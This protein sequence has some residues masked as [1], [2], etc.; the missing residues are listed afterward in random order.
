MENSR[1]FHLSERKK[2]SDKKLFVGIAFGGI[3]LSILSCW[4]FNAGPDTE[5]S[6]LLSCLF[7]IVPMA[8]FYMIIEGV[9]IYRETAGRKWKLVINEKGI[10]EIGHTDSK[11]DDWQVSWEEIREIFP[12]NPQENKQAIIIFPRTQSYSDYPY[13][14]RQGEVFYTSKYDKHDDKLY[15]ADTHKIYGYDNLGEIYN[16]LKELH[17]N[18]LIRQ[19]EEFAIQEQMRLE[20]LAKKEFIRQQQEKQYFQRIN[21]LEEIQKIDPIQFEKL[22]SSLFKKIGYDVL[23]TKASGDEGIDIILS[24]SGKKSIVQCKRYSGTVGQPVARDLYGSMIHNR[25]EEAYLITTGVFSL[26]AQTWATGKPIHLVDG[27]MLVE[28]IETILGKDGMG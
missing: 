8:G 17:Q 23:L 12:P 20:E 3:L 19:K 25:A 13:I 18:N 4:L 28:W 16:Y 10:S 21:R 7:V 22:V 15:P 24:K 6:L 9:T 11:K 2:K 27:K 5:G 14:I 1:E 26:P